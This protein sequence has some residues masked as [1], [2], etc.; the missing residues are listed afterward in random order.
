MIF[1]KNQS[2]E[3]CIRQ[4]LPVRF[5]AKI[6][7]F[8]FYFYVSEIFS[9]DTTCAETWI[10]YLFSPLYI[11]TVFHCKNDLDCYNKGICND[12]VCVCQPGWQE[13]TDCTGT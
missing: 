3:V 1:L 2:N 7:T 12:G 10:S 13:Q 8:F 11:L 5:K 9:V 4:G 6:D